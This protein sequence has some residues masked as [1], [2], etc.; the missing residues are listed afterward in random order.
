MTEA[1]GEERSVYNGG[2]SSTVVSAGAGRTDSG[3]SD[4]SAVE[5]NAG[6]ASV[7]GN[8]EKAWKTAKRKTAK[9]KRIF[10]GSASTY[11]ITKGLSRTSTCQKVSSIFKEVE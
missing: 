7:T 5:S 3:S 11:T 2:V 6:T 4:T 10:R 1:Q 9:E 8:C